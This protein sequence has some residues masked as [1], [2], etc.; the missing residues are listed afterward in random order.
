MKC[1][2]C[3]TVLKG[4]YCAHCGINIDTKTQL[5]MEI[6]KI[7]RKIKVLTVLECILV[8][9]FIILIILSTVLSNQQTNQKVSEGSTHRTVTYRSVG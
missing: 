6:G 4:N 8:P 2:K 1:P 3:K 7:N 9:A 5:E